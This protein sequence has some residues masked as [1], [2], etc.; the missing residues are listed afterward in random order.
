MNPEGRKRDPETGSK[1]SEDSSTRAAPDPRFHPWSRAPWKG[2]AF[3]ESHI[4]PLKKTHSEA[5]P[6]C[7]GSREQDVTGR[8][9]LL[10]SSRGEILKVTK[11]GE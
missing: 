8:P 5:R 2:D 6:G 9:G 10:E 11:C 1:L 7:L 4:P 3:G